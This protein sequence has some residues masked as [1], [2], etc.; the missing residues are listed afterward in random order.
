MTFFSKRFAFVFLFLSIFSTPAFSQEQNSKGDAFIDW[1]L[2]R[3]VTNTFDVKF[4]Q[5][6]KYNIFPFMFAEDRIA[7]SGQILS[8]LDGSPASKDNNILIKTVQTFGEPLTARQVKR[9]LNREA[10]KYESSARSIGGKLL[11]NEDF[12][13]NGVF[14]KNLYITYTANEQK[15]GIRIRLYVTNYSKIEQVLTAPASAMYSF[16]AEDFFNSLVPQLGIT[17]YEGDEVPGKGWIKYPSKNNVFTVTLPPKNSDFTPELP[18]FR[19]SPGRDSVEF[20]IV[21][22]VLLESAYYNVYSY[23]TGKALNYGDVKS[24]LFSNHVARFVNNAS[25]DSLDTDNTK[26]GDVNVMK[27]RLVITPIKRYPHVSVVVL[28]ARYIGDTVIIKEY[29]SNAS[30]SLSNLHNVLFKLTEFHPDKY[31]YTE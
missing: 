8:S 30:H 1:E 22:P 24:L 5:K 9:I 12:D 31:S 17:E 25:M 6:Y 14:G 7:F 10:E 18:A 15:Y 27:T 21:D 29:F 13:Q 4:P 19:S 23:K 16:R 26:D 11:S 20:E 3:S 28:E 2:H